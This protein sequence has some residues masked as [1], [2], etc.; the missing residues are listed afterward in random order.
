MTYDDSGVSIQAHLQIVDFE[1][2]EDDV[3]GHAFQVFPFVHD[4]AVRPDHRAIF[5]LN[6]PGDMGYHLSYALPPSRA[7][8]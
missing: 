2:G 3:A 8:S 4:A 1:F 6:P 7:E 5:R